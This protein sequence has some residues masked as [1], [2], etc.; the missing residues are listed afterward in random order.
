MKCNKERG[1]QV[2]GKSRHV[3]KETVLEGDTPA[4]VP[5]LIPCGSHTDHPNKPSRIPDLQNYEMQQ[6]GFCSLI[7]VY[8]AKQKFE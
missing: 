3:N 2:L 5:H 8:F 7:W 4:L 6:D 1:G